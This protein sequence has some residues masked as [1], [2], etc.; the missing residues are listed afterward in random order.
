MKILFFMP[1]IY[2]ILYTLTQLYDDL[3]FKISKIR[4]QSNPPLPVAHREELSDDNNVALGAGPVQKVLGAMQASLRRGQ[5][6]CN[7]FASTY[8]RTQH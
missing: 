3:I 8:T 6:P 4:K 7:Q 5:A 2:A 1:T